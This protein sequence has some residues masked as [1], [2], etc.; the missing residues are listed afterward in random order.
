MLWEADGNGR[1]LH[2]PEF[3]AFIWPVTAAGEGETV[4]KEKGT[5]HVPEHMG[6]PDNSSIREKQT[7]RSRCAISVSYAYGLEQT[8]AEC[9]P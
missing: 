3:L 1:G 2:V 6:L 9:D 8:N 5:Y 7:F 4:Y